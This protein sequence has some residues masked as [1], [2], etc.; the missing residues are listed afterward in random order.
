MFQWSLIL[1]RGLTKVL[2]WDIGSEHDSAAELIALLKEYF[3][4]IIFND[5]QEKC[6]F[7][8]NVDKFIRAS[9]C[10]SCIY[11]VMAV[12]TG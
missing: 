11:K 2:T 7:A 3:L 9:A 6:S 5:L 1:P 10:W 4:L 12:F 8:V